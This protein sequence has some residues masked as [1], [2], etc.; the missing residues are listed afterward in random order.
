MSQ[1]TLL[2]SLKQTL[3]VWSLFVMMNF[4]EE[5]IKN[6]NFLLILLITSSNDLK[7]PHLVMLGHTHEIN[8]W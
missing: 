1:N 5:Y 6:V 2:I 3:Y 4:E 8:K 7:E